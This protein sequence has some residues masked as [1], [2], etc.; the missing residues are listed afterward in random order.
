[1][2]K[3]EALIKIKELEEHIETLEEQ[4]L[5]RPEDLKIRHKG[6]DKLV[7]ALQAG[8]KAYD[9]VD[10]TVWNYTTRFNAE[11]TELTIGL[12]TELGYKD[13]FVHAFVKE[14]NR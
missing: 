12:A 3:E 14:M 2:N 8:V 6:F 4:I 11:G 7:R 13:D 1:M 10:F 5:L 9:G